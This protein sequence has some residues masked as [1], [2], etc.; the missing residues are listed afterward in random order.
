MLKHDHPVQFEWR[1]RR[2]SVERSTANVFRVFTTGPLD[3][4]LCRKMHPTRNPPRWWFISQTGPN[5][6]HVSRYRQGEP[7]TELPDT[8]YKS[9]RACIAGA[10]DYL[11][12][13]AVDASLT[14]RS[15]T[16]LD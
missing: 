13:V 16:V 7:G 15:E 4:K 3:V 14:R 6:R 2:F 9:L 1:G 8:V 10:A 12:S 5:G 11:C